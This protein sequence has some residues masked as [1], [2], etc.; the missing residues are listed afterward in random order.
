MISA[1]KFQ[2]LGWGGMLITAEQ[3]KNTNVKRALDVGCFDKIAAQYV[4]SNIKKNRLLS[5]HFFA[6][7]SMAA[8]RRDT[9]PAIVCLCSLKTA[10]IA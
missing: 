10:S 3:L 4:Y 9:G 1:I 7:W 2:E 5:H 6:S 8:T